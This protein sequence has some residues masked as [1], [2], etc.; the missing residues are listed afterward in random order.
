MGNHFV[1]FFHYSGTVNDLYNPIYLDVVMA[2][3][4]TF[5]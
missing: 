1:I 2:N 3:K 5:M 4:L